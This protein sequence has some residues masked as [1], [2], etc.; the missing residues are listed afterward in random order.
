MRYTEMRKGVM[1]MRY[2]QD[3]LKRMA[4]KD[5]RALEKRMCAWAAAAEL[6]S[7][8]TAREMVF[9]L[10]FW[11][12]GEFHRRRLYLERQEPE[13]ERHAREALWALS[14]KIKENERKP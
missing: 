10:L 12:H 3:T 9:D 2:D 7:E 5:Y 6:E 1:K 11:A 8:E 13:T 4:L 14:G